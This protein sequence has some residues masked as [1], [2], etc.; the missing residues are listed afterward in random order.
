[1][2]S[3]ADVGLPKLNFCEHSAFRSRYAGRGN[4]VNDLISTVGISAA[5]LTS[6]SYIPQVRKASPRHSTDDLSIRTLVAFTAGL[7]LWVLYGTGK[8]DWVIIGSNVIAT[9]LAG[10]VLVFKIR[11]MRRK[12]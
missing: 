1:M 7:A 6:L 11:D 2:S 9:G 5:L 4:V 8:G 10:T 3:K 12:R